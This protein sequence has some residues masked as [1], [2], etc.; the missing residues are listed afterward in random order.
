MGSDRNAGKKAPLR[1]RLGYRILR[2]AGRIMLRK[3]G[4]RTDELPADFEGPY[5]VM[6]NHTTEVDM[7]MVCQAFRRFMY[8]V[9]GEHL[10]RSKYAGIFRV[11]GDPIPLP[12]GGSSTGAVREIRRRIRAGSSVMIFPEGCRSFDGETLTLEPSVSKLVKMLGC[13]LVTY[14]TVGGYFVAPRWAHRFRTGPMEGRIAGQYTAEELRSMTPEEIT[15][16]INRDLYENAYETQRADPKAYVCDAPAEG[17]ENYLIICPRCGAYD[18]MVTK[19]DRFRCGACGLGG[20]HDEYGF[21]QGE[22]LPF[23]NVYDWGR[24][25]QDRFDEDMDRRDAGELLFT[26]TDVTLYEI[27]PDH[28]RQDLF[29]GTLEVCGDRYVIG[30]RTFAFADISASSLLYFGK[31]VLF[32]HKTGYFALTGE[33]YHAWK[34]HRLY[35]RCHEALRGARAGRGSLHDDPRKLPVSEEAVGVG[36]AAPV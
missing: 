14:H 27:L 2:L 34:S 28:S 18:A 15:S 22:D 23:D 16:R 5:I 32:T 11:L 31:S 24:W 26:E 19:G 35:E 17:L 4:F 10:F 12:R 6:A 9:C 36:Q 29:T 7:L 33:H 13:G 1:Y 25:M 21:L 3:Y 8:F 20:V 30:G